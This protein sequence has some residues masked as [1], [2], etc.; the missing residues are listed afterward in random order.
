[1]SGLEV[2]DLCVRRGGVIALDG[3]SLQLREGE[4]LAVIGP[5]GAG[6][7]TLVNAVSR[8]LRPERG[9]IRFGGRNLLRLPPSRLAELGIARSFQ[10][11]ELFENSSVLQNLLSARHVHR[12]CGL[13]PQLLF[14]PA[15]LREEVAHRRAVEE[16]IEFLNLEAHRDRRIAGL[17]YGVRKIV[18][19][20]RALAMAPRLL[21]LDEPASGLSLDETRILEDCIR[22]IRRRSGVA[23]LMVEHDMRLV[24][25]LAD[26][27]LALAEGRALQT[28]SPDEVLSHPEVAESYLGK[29]AKAQA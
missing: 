18:E 2:R 15:V 16:V 25:D 4:I 17:P 9:T 6:K 10:N 27:V 23:V 13:L 7:T 3:L 29:P 24:A 11:L 5:N 20:G 14:T 1:M 21:L 22:E 19:I 8:F 28:G 12:R 26:R